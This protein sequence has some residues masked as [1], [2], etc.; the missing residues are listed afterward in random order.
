[1]LG[2][3]AL[4]HKSN[5]NR[6]GEIGPPYHN[7]LESKNISDRVT[8]EWTLYSCS[9]MDGML[10]WLDIYFNSLFREANFY[11]LLE[12]FPTFLYCEGNK[13]LCCV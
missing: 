7:P 2:V 4:Y 10:G 6:R 11:I 12:D 5:K 8:C 9:L 3:A 1:M 13:S